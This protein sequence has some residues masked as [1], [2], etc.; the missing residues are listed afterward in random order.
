MQRTLSSV[1]EQGSVWTNESWSSSFDSGDVDSAIHKLSAEIIQVCSRGVVPS[2]QTAKLYLARAILF[3]ERMWLDLAEQDLEASRRLDTNNPELFAFKALFELAT[4]SSSSSRKKALE[5][6]ASAL[7]S[8]LEGNASKEILSCH[9]VRALAQLNSG[10][11]SKCSAHC[12]EA[13]RLSTENPD[14]WLIRGVSRSTQKSWID[15]TK[16]L[17]KAKQLRCRHPDL[18]ALF[19]ITKELRLAETRLAKGKD[20]QKNVV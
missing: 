15:S 14:S 4:S 16:D 8:A 19:R 10:N 7:R 12:T 6:S 1:E 11:L 20:N 18:D 9:Q 5:S 17:R 13:L 3:R 2:R